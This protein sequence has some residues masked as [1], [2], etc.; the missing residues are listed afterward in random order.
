MTETKD[1]SVETLLSV[2]TGRMMGGSFDDVHGAVTHIL[3]HDIWTHELA[4]GSIWT[5]AQALLFAQ[6]PDLQIEVP[7]TIDEARAMQTV[8][9][10]KTALGTDR[11]EVA[12]GVDTRTESPV[13]SL[14]RVAPGKPIVVV[15][16][17]PDP[18]AEPTN[19]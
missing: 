16:G 4:D 12:K 5:R 7:D 10:T 9:D 19:D 1:F 17:R 11:L 13:E 15:G 3:G 6:H 8:A 18:A 2:A 14:Q